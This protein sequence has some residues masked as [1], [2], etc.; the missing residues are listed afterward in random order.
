MKKY[1]SYS[2]VLPWFM[3]LILGA[4]LDKPLL[5]NQKSSSVY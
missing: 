4:L 5:P 2:R 1:E 3:A